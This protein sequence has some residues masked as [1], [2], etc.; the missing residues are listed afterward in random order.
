MRDHHEPEEVEI[1]E[2]DDSDDDEDQEPEEFHDVSSSY[3]EDPPFEGELQ[4]EAS[5]I[6][7]RSE[8]AWRRLLCRRP[9][10]VN[11]ED[12]CCAE[13]SSGDAESPRMF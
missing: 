10:T 6:G 4:E 11:Q 1:Q 3:R 7:S 9:N 12:V 5:F 8:Y 2:E 13:V